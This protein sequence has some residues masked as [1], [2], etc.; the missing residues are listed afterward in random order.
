[1]FVVPKG[2][3]HRPVA[4]R[5]AKVMLIEPRGVANTGD[6]P[7]ALTAAENAWI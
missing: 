2:L 1:M 7:G 4:E 6:H 3:E 5:E